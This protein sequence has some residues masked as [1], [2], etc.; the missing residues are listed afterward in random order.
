MLLS[1]YLGNKAALLRP[2]LD[3]TATRCQPGDRVLDAFAGSLAV[4]MAYK[5]AGYVVSAND[6]NRL[7]DTFARAYLANCEVPEVGFAAPR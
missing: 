7:T 5:N 4:S 2:I 3:I 1:R 6:I